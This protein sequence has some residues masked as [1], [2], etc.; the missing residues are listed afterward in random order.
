MTVLQRGERLPLSRF[1]SE[2]E[3]VLTATL[4]MSSPPDLSLFGLD[5]EG[6][7]S[8]DR[9]LVFY[10]QRQSPEQAIQ[11]DETGRSFSVNLSRIPLGIHRLLLTATHDDLPFSTLKEGRATL[12]VH[13]REFVTFEVSGAM[14][15]SERAVMLLEVYRRQNEWRIAG[16]GQGFS[17]G[18]QALLE[19]LG[20]SVADVPDASPPASP[21]PLSPAPKLIWQPLES[22]TWALQSSGTCRRCGR[23][24]GF[25]R[26][27]DAQQLCRDCANEHQ[28]GLQRF[29]VRFQAACA[30]NIMELHE[31][32]DLQQT[33]RQE[34]LKADEALAFV[35]PQAVNLL[36]RTV[37]MARADGVLEPHEEE[38]FHRLARLLQV[39]DNL[40]THARADLEELR[41]ATTLRAGILPTIR[42]TLILESGEIAHFEAPTTYRHITASRTRL[43]PGRLTLTSKQL[44]F[45]G[46]EGGWNIQYAKVLRIEEL[47]GGV[48]LELG[49]KKGSGVYQVDRSLLLAAT[50]DALVRI[51]KRLMLIPQTEKASRHIPQAVRNQVW[52]HDQG[53]CRECGD[54]NYL[55]FDHIIPFSKGGAS[56]FGNLQLLCRR[57]NLKK[58]D[59]L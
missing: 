31:W 11:L 54:S 25:L 2:P 44:H 58:G 53:K 4:P 55:E 37:M 35:R 41:A 9:Y 23:A 47:S 36:E 42:S 57:C 12:K 45:V 24:G 39:P 28:A 38:A 50:L 10:N 32:Q 46:P 40:L 19:S 8:D 15:Q 20:G 14:F 16:I 18:L 43:L 21:V 29:R 3:F 48:N 56:S 17:G 49:I 26:R 1:T 51:Q 52:Q 5:Q 6:K 30:D 27:L 34:R 22:A 59:R 33:I 13:G 7:L